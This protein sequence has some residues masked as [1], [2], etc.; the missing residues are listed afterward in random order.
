MCRIGCLAGY[1]YDDDEKALKI[2]SFSSDIS[3]SQNLSFLLKQI[4]NI[5]NIL[6]ET[7]SS[8][9]KDPI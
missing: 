7:V 9:D 4:D 8:K 5:Q 1:G 3:A 6:H 2:V